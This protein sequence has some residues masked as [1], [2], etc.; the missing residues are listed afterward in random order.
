MDS[1]RRVL[2]GRAAEAAGAGWANQRIAE[3]QAERRTIQGG[4][5]GTLREARA[6]LNNSL[7]RSLAA[8][9]V[10]PP[11]R[12]E[13]EQAVRQAYAVARDTWRMHSQPDP[14]EAAAR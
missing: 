9:A 8:E 5:P 4:W 14:E 3:L 12:E 10:S 6:F 2:L 13:L 1:A 7:P 11:T